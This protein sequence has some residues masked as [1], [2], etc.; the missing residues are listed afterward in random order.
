MADDDKAPPAPN[1]EEDVSVATGE[2]DENDTTG[3]VGV[4][5]IYQN[6]ADETTK[7]LVAE[8]GPAK[9]LEEQ[10]KQREEAL[11]VAARNVGVTGYTGQ[12]NPLT[13]EPP[14]KTREQELRQAAK[15][16][17]TLERDREKQRAEARKSVLG[18]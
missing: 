1:P 11:A 3:Y 10:A 13:R 2:G 12:A 15:R 8:E 17:A 5:P 7:P 16:Q 18:S 9:F 14:P 4:D 6:Y